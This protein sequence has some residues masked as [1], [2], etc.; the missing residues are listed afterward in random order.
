MLDHARRHQRISDGS[1][2]SM[3]FGNKLAE[4][5]SD[6]SPAT[7]FSE[8]F[9]S[10]P[11]DSSVDFVVKSVKDLLLNGKISPG[12]R[13]P[14]EFELSKFLGVS[15]G[16]VREAVKILSALGILEIRRGN[17]TFVRE[18]SSG[19]N[20]DPLL[21]SLIVSRPK[22][23]ELKELRL[24]LEQNVARLA[25]RNA[26]ETDLSS[27]RSCVA[28]MSALKN[29]GEEAYSDLL[30]CDLD[31]HRQLGKA[32]RNSPLEVIY[33]FIMQYFRT[34]IEQS[35]HRHSAFSKE[36]VEAHDKILRALEDRNIRAANRAVEESMDTWES[37]VSERPRRG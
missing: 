30:E 12:E 27:L 23:S 17:G 28:R 14:T 8:L 16:S 31:F 21:F 4:G 24:I 1:E 26:T 11:N 15:R 7:G 29:S 22:F 18:E 5:H 6:R 3:S 33:G 13:L 34:S 25:T 10:K 9:T 2:R 35:L 37:L 32:A 19:A 36:S 20:F